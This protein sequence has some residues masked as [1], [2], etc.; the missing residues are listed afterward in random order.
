MITLLFLFVGVVSAIVVGI[1]LSKLGAA[2]SRWPYAAIV[3]AAAAI[4][5]L[6]QSPSTPDNWQFTWYAGIAAFAVLAVLGLFRSP[7][8]IAIGLL[9]HGVFDSAVTIAGASTWVGSAYG[10]WCAG[11]DIALSLI[12]ILRV[13][14]TPESRISRDGDLK[15]S[16]I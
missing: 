4:Y 12:F 7:W 9:L 14:V 6:I 13:C 10:P 3:V 16:K 8:W 5:L 2:Y 15:S 1:V 11:F